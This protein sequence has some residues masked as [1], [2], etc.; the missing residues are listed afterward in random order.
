MPRMRWTIAV[1]AFLV[2]VGLAAAGEPLSPPCDCHG[3]VRCPA[4]P[5][6]SL[7]P[8]CCEPHRHCFD[9]AWD[10]YCQ[11]RARWDAVL[12]SRRH[13][14]IV[15]LRAPCGPRPPRHRRGRSSLA[16]RGGLRMRGFSGDR[17]CR[18]A[19]TQLIHVVGGWST[20]AIGCARANRSYR[21]GETSPG[22]GSVRNPPFP[23]GFASRT[24][25]FVNNPG[26]RSV[27]KICFRFRGRAA[28]KENIDL[29]GGWDTLCP[30]S[31]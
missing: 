11:Q 14:F 10:G 23:M 27:R 12:E 31:G 2:G 30:I 13:R 19:L 21:H 9:N 18:A 22:F 17:S 24:L 15:S 6:Y 1:G 3:S 26:Q 28:D 8:G 25:Q 4:Q 7:S 29:P 5:S 20:E 16:G